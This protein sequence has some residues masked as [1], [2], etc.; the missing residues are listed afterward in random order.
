[1]RSPRPS[2]TT[3]S[4]SSAA[5]FIRAG[6]AASSGSNALWGQPSSSRRYNVGD[7]LEALLQTEPD[8]RQFALLR[9]LEAPDSAGDVELLAPEEDDPSDAVQRFLSA[10]ELGETVIRWSSV[11]L[12]GLRAS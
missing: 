7:S 6:Y 2:P 9:H 3:R 5:Q 12:R 11:P 8:G 10:F 4:S 1:M